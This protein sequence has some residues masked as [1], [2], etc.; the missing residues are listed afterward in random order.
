MRSFIKV[1]I[2]GVWLIASCPLVAQ[3]AQ[4]ISALEYIEKYKKDAVIDMLKSGV[5]ASI[6]LA[7]GML[8]SGNGN[9]PLAIEARNHFGIKCHKDWQG[10]TYTQDDDAKNECF[11]KYKSVLE[12][13]DDHSTFL[14]TRTRYAFLFEMERSN[15]KGW[16]EGLKR[17]GY[18][19]NPFYPQL[20]IKIIEEHQL[21]ELD[22]SDKPENLKTNRKII[23]QK[24]S[25]SVKDIALNNNVQYITVGKGESVLFICQKYNLDLWQVYKYN[26]IDK[27]A[28]ITEGQR[29]YIKPKRRRGAADYHL[30]K[31]DETMHSISQVYGIKLK[32]LYRKNRMEPGTEAEVGQKLWLRSKKPAQ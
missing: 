6:T 5:P 9:S 7:Q 4:K 12:S 14:K 24:P 32:L 30:V 21:Y 10:D 31:N 15:Y 13:F 18:A 29:L 26:D 1:V 25:P 23:A 20:L 19:T 16:A 3:V 2:L 8:E 27:N 28:N 11:R 22:K 17:A